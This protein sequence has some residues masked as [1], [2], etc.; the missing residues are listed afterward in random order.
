M[1]LARVLRMG[2]AEILCRARQEAAK[3]W[4]ALAVGA[5]RRPVAE[6]ALA[7]DAFCR[8]APGRFFDGA[9]SGEAPLLVS[10]DHLDETVAVAQA[11]SRGRF[12][13]LGY[14]GLDFGD[15]ID[16]HLDP[17]SGRRAPR[18]HWSRLD[19]LDAAVVG[20]NKVVWELNRHQWLVRLGVA[21]RLTG[22]ERHAEVFAD[23]VRAW[24]RANPRGLGLNWASS[25]EV[26]LRIV[27][28]CWALVLFRESR[29]LSPAL[30]AEMLGGIRAHAAHVERYL[31]HYF[32]PNTHLTGEALGLVYAG[33]VFPELREARRWRTLGTRI[34]LAELERQAL[35]DGVHFERST[36]YQRYTAE[37]YLHFMLL[38]ARNGLTLPDRVGERVQQLVDVLVALRQPDGTLPAIGDADGGWLLPLASRAPGDARGVYSVAA[39]LFGRADYHWAA[40]GVAP[41]TVWLLGSAGR[42]ACERL[43]PAPPA[44]P[45]RAFIDGG[46]VVMRSGWDP[47]AHQLILDAGPL[48]CPSN[49]GHGH[50]DL[51]A[52]Q[53]VVFGRPCLVDAGTYTYTAEPAWRD[54]FR[55]TGAHSTVVVDGVEQAAPAGPFKWRTR[56]G[57][58]LTRWSSGEILEVAEAWHDAYRRLPDPVTHRRRIRFVKPRYWLVIDDLEG[59][60]EHAIDLRFQF[61]R[62]DLS[63]DA[64]LSTRA[65]IDGRAGLLLRPFAAAPLK[66]EV[67]EGE[68]DPP[69][70]WVSPDYGVRHPAPLVRY[71]TVTRLPLRIV[72]LLYPTEDVLAEP[73]AAV[74]DECRALAVTDV[75]VTTRN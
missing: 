73:P 6:T 30:F 34:L 31:S 70:G 46:I 35:P 4:D 69:R 52:I 67:H 36:C 27:A 42:A 50:A 10:R 5:R 11:V 37:I 24:W 57:A 21:Y 7:L 60:A 71:T 45:S 41:E 38:A 3:R 18:G 17:I 49:A 14:R 39:A 75:V 65:W 48:G 72:T 66:A 32:A 74:L 15:P 9:A 1:K 26:A 12:D 47:R 20:D 58:R 40:G 43:L 28:W 56:P 33:V 53:C 61:A 2:P 23:R 13:L 62:L 63:V 68:L 44:A 29:A 55:G 19:P 22:D 25:L 8:L 64:S 51:L 16:W 59:A 54:F